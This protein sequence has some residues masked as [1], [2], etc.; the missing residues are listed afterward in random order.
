LDEPKKDIFD[1]LDI[2]DVGAADPT[3]P[4]TP[5]APPVVTSEPAPPLIQ[6]VEER[7]FGDRRE[8]LINAAARGLAR[9]GSGFATIFG[10]EENGQ[11][12]WEV[13]KQ[14][15][16]AAKNTDLLDRAINLIGETIPFITATTVASLPTYGIGGFFVGATVEG[17]SAYREALDEGVD[18]E[19]ARKIGTGVGIVSGAIE[20]VGGKFAGDLFDRATSKLRNK[21]IRRGAKFAAATF[22]EALEEGSQELTAITGE[23]VY[24]DVDWNEAVSRTGG[25]M[26]GG[27]FLGGLFKGADIATRQAIKAGGGGVSAE[28]IL[29]E[30][31][32]RIG[33]IGGQVSEQLVS[34]DI[35]ESQERAIRKLEEE[36]KITPSAVEGEVITSVKEKDDGGQRDEER[37]EELRARDRLVESEQRAEEAKAP[38]EAR[39]RVVLEE[40]RQGLTEEGAVKAALT[41]A[42][43][44]KVETARPFQTQFKDVNLND[45]D[46]KAIMSDV[47]TAFKDKDLSAFPDLRKRA[48]KLFNET[49]ENPGLYNAI[50]VLEGDLEASL[51]PTLAT[52]VKAVPKVLDKT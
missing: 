32:P 4:R 30:G 8:E 33:T 46:V 24:R 1:T 20:T 51:A 18:E 5:A 22:V 44:G 26:A 50:N 21:I 34:Q 48:L 16:I 29:Q 43:E 17:N 36:G 11:L 38:V 2:F 3:I 28:Q 35:Q 52:E 41:P 12:L 47:D 45:P 9:V 39:K 40:G 27:A 7:T 13:A 31:V 25:A 42:V 6:P 10:S 19:T 23:T 15:D 49:N 37:R 14:P